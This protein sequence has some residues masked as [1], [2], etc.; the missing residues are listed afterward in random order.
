MKEP[1]QRGAQ[2]PY[3]RDCCIDGSHIRSQ[4]FAVSTCTFVRACRLQRVIRCSSAGV[5]NKVD[6]RLSGRKKIGRGPGR[7]GIAT[8]GRQKRVMGK[9]IAT[10]ARI[11]RD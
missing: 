3:F 5:G 1:R 6:I 11:E 8:R 4:V 7:G 10:E 2:L 9:E